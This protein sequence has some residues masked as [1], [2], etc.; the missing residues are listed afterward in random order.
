FGPDVRVNGEAGPV[1]LGTTCNLVVTISLN[2]TA[3]YLGYPQ[4]W[5]VVAAAPS[6]TYYMNSSMAWTTTVSPAYQG[7]LFGVQSHQV[8]DITGLPAGTYI[9]YFGIDTLN[10]VIDP[11]ILYDS[12]TVI[13]AP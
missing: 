11:D 13:V 1:T 6:G 8:L 2:P 10:G 12:A 4:D 9:F 7:G 5:W 3:T